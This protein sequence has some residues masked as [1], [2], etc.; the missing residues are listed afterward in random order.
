[1]KI[2]LADDDLVSRR[3]LQAN[4]TRWGYQVVTAGDGAEAWELLQAENPPRVAILDWMMPSMDGLEVCR[5]VR[6]LRRDHYTYILL[7]TGKDRKENVIEGMEA[8]AD[9]YLTKPFNSTEL[10]VRLH[11]GIRILDL[12]TQLIA[13]REELRDQATH[14]SLTRLWNRQ[15]ILDI[16]H[17]E[18]NR[19][20]REGSD[21]ALIMADLDHFKLINDRY[22]HAAGDEVLKES[23]RRFLSAV[24]PYDS[25][26][27]IGGEE[28]LI[29]VPGSDSENAVKQAE[30]L[31]RRLSENFI[32]VAG[33]DVRITVSLGVCS[34]AEMS[35]LE[36]EALVRAADTALY[37]AKN[38]GRDCV[39][40]YVPA[41]GERTAKTSSL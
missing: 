33:R 31:R 13:A 18:L 30:R 1:M 3:V 37:A 26:G 23:A 21:I 17:R 41:D 29:I 4:L 2:L 38:S 34:A 40:H 32:R 12:E 16:L 24:R 11:A 9:D 25:V 8:G 27:R 22:G 5:R 7:L 6:Q 28:F 39:R 10:K 35:E 19:A 20:R 15:A 36:P 14:D